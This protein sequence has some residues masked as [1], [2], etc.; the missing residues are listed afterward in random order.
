MITIFSSA[1]DNVIKSCVGS[2]M[3]NYAFALQSLIPLLDR[4]GEQRKTQSKKFY[5]RLRNDILHGCI[6]PPITLA[7][8]NQTFQT[9]STTQAL[10]QF[11]NNNIQEGYILDG[12]QRLNTLRDASTDPNF[13]NQRPIH[14]NVIVAERYDLLLYRMITLNN[15][16]KPMT[17]R[18]Q[19]EMLT[20]G[21]IDISGMTIQ[22]V[23]E[24]DTDGTKIHGAFKL[25]DIVEAYT[26]YLT[27]SVNNQNSKI[28]ETKLDEI[29]VGKVMDSNLAAATITFPEILSEINRLSSHIGNRDWLRQANN[30][31]GF[32]VGMRESLRVVALWTPE[33]FATSHEKFDAAFN[34][35]NQS[36]VNLGKYRRE[37]SAYYYSNANRFAKMDVQEIESDFFDFTI[38][39]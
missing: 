32:T 30:L 29:I 38:A 9:P 21:V 25:S 15:G 34:S 27:N 33:E 22:I 37:L 28:I 1:Q 19:I 36:K 35:I 7:F 11:V 31:I 14:I 5:A 3:S 8:V 20:N 12:L 13:D 26:S 2:A 23:T 16:Q 24:K 39:D 18:H 6:M 10:E 17:A 4:F